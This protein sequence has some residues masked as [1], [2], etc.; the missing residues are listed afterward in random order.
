MNYAR[1][2]KQKLKCAILMKNIAEIRLWILPVNSLTII[3]KSSILD[4]VA[5][6]DPFVNI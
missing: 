1:D 4:A 2:K 5:V 3:T 6:L